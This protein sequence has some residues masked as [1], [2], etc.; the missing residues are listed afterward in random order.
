VEKLILDP[1]PE[2]IYANR[3]YLAYQA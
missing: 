2:L 3:S 1:D